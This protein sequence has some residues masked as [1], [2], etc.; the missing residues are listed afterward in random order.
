MDINSYNINKS[1]LDR[2]NN[3][4]ND[5]CNKI[6]KKKIN[7]RYNTNMSLIL[8]K[9]NIT[10][11]SNF[12]YNILSYYYIIFVNL[13]RHH[14]KNKSNILVS[15]TYYINNLEKKMLKSIIENYKLSINKYKRILF[16]KKLKDLK[17]SIF[18]LKSAC[19]YNKLKLE[20]KINILK[21]FIKSLNTPVFI[22]LFLFN[23]LT[24][25]SCKL[26]FLNTTNCIKT[27]TK[28]NI[29]VK[30]FLMIRK[31]IMFKYIF[32]TIYFKYK[33]IILRINML[34]FLKNTCINISKKDRRKN[35]NLKANKY[36]IN[37]TAKNL[38]L[39]CFNILLKNLNLNI[40][41]KYDIA[42]NEFYSKNL[43]LKYFINLITICK[44]TLNQKLNMSY[45]F[46]CF[47][48]KKYFIIFF[49]EM[50]AI[51]KIVEHNKYMYKLKS[52]N[53]LKFNYNKNK[54]IKYKISNLIV[55]ILDTIN[56]KYL[57]LNSRYCF[58]LILLKSINIHKINNVY[59]IKT[60]I[61]KKNFLNSMKLNTLINKLQYKILV[62]KFKSTLKHLVYYTIFTLRK[63][64]K[65]N[66][67]I[68]YIRAKKLNKLKKA[69]IKSL[70]NNYFNY[71][72]NNNIAIY[73]NSYCIK[74]KH[75]MLFKNIILNNI[76]YKENITYKFYIDN[77]K[78][79]VFNIV[80]K[81]YR[82]KLRE[83]NI[84]HK[85]KNLNVKRLKKIKISILKHWNLYIKYKTFK[86]KRNFKLK[87][88]Y[89]YN[90]LYIKYKFDNI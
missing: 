30:F 44:N 40:N 17:K 54:T 82:I 1:I 73:Y 86:K 42:Y 45:N 11:D 48:L 78:N 68:Q 62:N 3:Y 69:L 89:F 33:L 31:S 39:K 72:H 16:I 70:N 51:K 64:E 87:A 57:Y 29:L 81:N 22:K 85:I 53:C 24:L 15:N 43:K 28:I 38:K 9:N 84:I 56:K 55:M 36:Y 77:L 59:L 67:I 12:E 65:D 83:N 60:N 8:Q 47:K 32:K 49:K 58:K 13:C 35:I 90:I 46:Y 20:E 52:F 71:F 19:T 79:K 80:L 6:F 50:L 25:V 74:L 14:I 26:R 66:L 61:I 63:K 76:H 18:K 41:L 75:Y 37:N 2:C 7:I 34:L 27:N 21:M 88:K 4:N 10:D 5:I 23:T